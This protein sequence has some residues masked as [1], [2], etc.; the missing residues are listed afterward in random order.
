MKNKGKGR[1]MEVS[2][3]QR[4]HIDLDKGVVPLPGHSAG[5]TVSH[6][7]D[8]TVNCSSL[9]SPSSSR[10]LGSGKT[11]PLTNTEKNFRTSQC[12]VGTVDVVLI[13]ILSMWVK[14]KRILD[15]PESM[16]TCFSKSDCYCLHENW[17]WSCAGA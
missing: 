2:T 12:E 11:R 13:Y 16:S 15:L 4:Y 9:A 8:W 3:S 6:D 10:K 1:G 5:A 7:M 17:I 14:G